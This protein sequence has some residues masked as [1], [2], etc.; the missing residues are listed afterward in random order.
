MLN[1]IPLIDAHVHATRL[2]TLKAPWKE[3]AARYGSPSL[4]ELYDDQGRHRE[5]YATDGHFVIQ[6][7]HFD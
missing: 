3:W 2:P 4:L 7:M 1:G 5:S 6:Y